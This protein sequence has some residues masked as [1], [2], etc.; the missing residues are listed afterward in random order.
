MKRRR[1][2]LIAALSGMAIAGVLFRDRMEVTINRVRQRVAKRTVND[3][4]ATF[5]D[6]ARQR[7]AP[8]FQ[9]AGVAYPPREILLIALKT[10]KSLEL[11]AN[12]AMQKKLVRRY[13]I[14]AASGRPGPKLREGDQQ[15]PEGIYAVESLNPNSAYHVSLRL[16]YPNVFDR[17]QAAKDSRTRLGGDI[18]I[19]GKA[20]SIGCI[21]VGDEAAEEL[22]TLAADVGVTNV[23]VICSPVDLRKRKAEVSASPSPDWI[24]ELYA[25]IA[26]ELNS[27]PAE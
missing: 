11:Y 9:K 7:L 10:E 18:M 2:I 20:V 24:P 15:V 14:L 22:F 3:R 26:R 1:L 8:Y 27:L 16:N 19:H 25:D 4:L 23:K 17:T 12:D 21:A 13:P 6:S 5:G